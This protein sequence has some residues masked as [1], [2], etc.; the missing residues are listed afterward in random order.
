MV[1]ESPWFS[2]NIR[3][4]NTER[5]SAIAGVHRTVPVTA[6][7]L[8]LLEQTSNIGVEISMKLRFT[9]AIAIVLSCTLLLPFTALAQ[10]DSQQDDV[11][12]AARKAREKK[13][14]HAKKVVTDDDDSGIKSKTS[15]PE[16][17]TDGATNNDEI[18]ARV[19][20]FK[21]THTPQETEAAVRAW[22][23]QHTEKITQLLQD[24]RNIAE[25]AVRREDTSDDGQAS[26]AQM[27]AAEQDSA[28]VRDEVANARRIQSELKSVLSSLKQLSLEYDLKVPDLKIDGVTF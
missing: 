21:S 9:I 20:E 15:F 25:R 3:L 7:I 22:F 26:S 27:H 6:V 28:R 5:L 1:K 23:E 19:K 2:Y 16:L 8:V 12:E 24:V 14:A 18:V 11:A 13:T 4:Q 10:S 17:K